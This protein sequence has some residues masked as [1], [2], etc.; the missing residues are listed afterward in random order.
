[1]IFL[2][3]PLRSRGSRQE[4]INLTKACTILCA[5]HAL[6][7]VYSSIK[8]VS[9]APNFACWKMKSY[10]SSRLN[11]PLLCYLFCKMILFLHYTFLSGQTCLLFETARANLY[12]FVNT[13][14]CQNQEN[15]DT[16]LLVCC[17]KKSCMA[18]Q[19]ICI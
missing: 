12:F 6:D 5:M 2:P 11:C 3:L 13:I 8:S 14:H 7:R 1:M 4:S 15:C 18:I 16:N 17:I 19:S 9:V 10:V